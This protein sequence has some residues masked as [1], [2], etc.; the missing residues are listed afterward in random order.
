MADQIETDEAYDQSVRRKF[1]PQIDSRKAGRKGRQKKLIG[2]ADGRSLRETGRTEQINFKAQLAIKV[3]LDEHVGAGR[4][5]MW[6]EEAIIAKLEA[7]GYK[8]DG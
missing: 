8:I 4:K 5:S 6:L 1:A 7:E 2:A 3:A